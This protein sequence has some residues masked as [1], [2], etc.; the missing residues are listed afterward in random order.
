MSALADR[1]IN[2]A[3]RANSTRI[4][5]IGLDFSL[6]EVHLVQLQFDI[7]NRITLRAST[8]LPYSG[9]R[10]ELLAAPKKLRSLLQQALKAEHFRGKAV[11]TTLPASD[12]RI[13][14]VSYQAGE[15]QSDDAALLHSLAERVDH[16]LNDYVIDYL[17][18]RAATSSADRLAIVTLARRETV[19]GYLEVLRKAGLEIRQL[20]IGP[21]AIRRLVSSMGA[22]DKHENVLAI[23]FG[24]TASYITV[25]SGNRL[26]LD[27]EIHCGETGLLENIAGEL[28]MSVESV[29]VLLENNNISP[30]PPAAVAGSSE[31]DIAGTL[32][33]IIKPLLRGLTEE[34]NRVLVYTA[35]QTHGEVISRIYMM[36][37]LARWQGMDGL[38]NSLI[39]LPVETIP[40]PLKSFGNANTSPAG[41]QPRPEIAVATG[42]ALN[43]FDE[44]V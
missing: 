42:L 23:N 6:T 22:Q 10:E 9:T 24:R 39:K 4:G 13:M 1:F 3:W 28:D 29:R 8:S 7:N 18:V 2:T 15:G 33:E 20:E 44:D 32:Q 12:T 5:P 27:Q 26:L 16:D 31:I 38:L 40:D 11:V 43:G 35:S 34:I 25:V 19:I 21:V 36:G 37:S 14:A 17:P 30:Q 41:R